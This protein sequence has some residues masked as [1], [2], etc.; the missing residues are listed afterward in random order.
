[1]VLPVSRKPSC[2]TYRQSVP[3]MSEEQFEEDRDRPRKPVALAQEL[4]LG[5]LESLINSFVDLDPDTRQQ[6]R[7]RDG[8]IVRVKAVDPHMI[9]YLHFTREGIEL[10]A[11]APGPATVRIG[12][13]LLSLLS[14]IA[15][16]H[17]L[18]KPGKIRIWG[19]STQVNWLIELLNAFNLRTSAQRWLRRHLN[20]GELWHKIRRND[21][22][23]ISDL[24]P[25]PGMMREALAEIRTLRKSLDQ[26]QEA[27]R[28]QQ[29]AW[30]QQRPWDIGILVVV[31]AT[32]VLA[33]LPGNTLVDRIDGLTPE[34]LICIGL[35]LALIGTR[36]WRR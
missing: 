36:F 11:E 16:Q 22:S 20:I 26:Q 24:M 9:C 10:S 28:D 31:M 5:M 33:L 14:A 30:Q 27:W 7:A 1:M 12:G 19:E 6:V 8:L 23:W 13:S 18:D 2:G 3:I 25:M 21:P 35:A 29:Y 34:R 4:W 15:G 32:L 17:S